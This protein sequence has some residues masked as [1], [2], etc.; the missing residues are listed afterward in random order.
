MKYFAIQ[1]NGINVLGSTLIISIPTKHKKHN[2]EHPTMVTH[3]VLL[4]LFV[5]ENMLLTGIPLAMPVGSYPDLD[6]IRVE[7]Y[8]L[9]VVTILSVLPFLFQVFFNIC[10]SK[11]NDIYHLS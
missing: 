1:S 6:C 5:F 8:I 4:L 3:T 11:N 10:F 9:E 2:D 7:R